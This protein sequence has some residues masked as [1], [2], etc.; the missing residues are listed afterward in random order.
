[1]I[2][3]V[4]IGAGSGFGARTLVDLLSFEP[5]RDS[6]IVLVDINPRHLKPVAD[7]ARKLIAHHRCTTKIVTADAWRAGSSTGPTS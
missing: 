1:M 2:K 4:F 6:E 3:I 5:L 7:Y